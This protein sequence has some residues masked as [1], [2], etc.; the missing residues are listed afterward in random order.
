MTFKLT[1]QSSGALPYAAVD[2]SLNAPSGTP[3]FPTVLNGYAARPP[4]KVAGIDYRVGINTGIVLTAPSA[5]ANL[6]VVGHN[7][8]VNAANVT[9]DSVDFTDFSVTVQTA[10]VTFTNCK[11]FVSPGNPSGLTDYWIGLSGSTNLTVQYCE[12]DFTNF[13]S[14]SRVGMINSISATTTVKYN[15]FKNAYSDT[16]N[17][18]GGVVTIMYNLFNQTQAFEAGAHADLFQMNGSGC[19]LVAQFN[20][21][22]LNIP[23]SSIN[24]AQAFYLANGTGWVGTQDCGWNT[25]T[26]SGT[27]NGDAVGGS[28]I[29]LFGAGGLAP[30][31]VHDNYI[32][33]LWCRTGTVFHDLTGVTATGNINM[34]TSAAENS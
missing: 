7:A 3:Q 16:V 34:N 18:A 8:T 2:G 20:G 17:V 12:F 15:Y 25:F 30:Y 24:G 19:T 10:N 13:S 14:N 29:G 23:G 28:Y 26:G 21:C 9:I 33:P 1:S 6:T 31:N 11:F 32:D 22:V 27:P 5:N 4:W